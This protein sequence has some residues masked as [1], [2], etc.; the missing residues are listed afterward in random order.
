MSN[1]LQVTPLIAADRFPVSLL[2]CAGNGEA[3]LLHPKVR[4]ILTY[5][6]GIGSTTGGRMTA[7]SAPGEIV[8]DSNWTREGSQ[9]G[10]KSQ[11]WIVETELGQ[12]AIRPLGG[13]GCG[14]RL[15]HWTPEQFQPYRLGRPLR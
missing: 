12:I 2:F 4:V 7:W 8:L 13:C 10:A 9:F 14:D 5:D 11:D 6:D 15:K 3:T 1:P